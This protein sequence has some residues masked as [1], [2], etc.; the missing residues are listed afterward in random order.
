[1][2]LMLIAAHLSSHLTSSKSWPWIWWLDHGH[3]FEKRRLTA[4]CVCWRELD[5]SAGQIVKLF[6]GEPPRHE[7]AARHLKLVSGG[8]KTAGLGWTCSTFS[9]TL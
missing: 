9:T 3:E 5:P 1:M 2:S 4:S 6:D 8:H 7:R